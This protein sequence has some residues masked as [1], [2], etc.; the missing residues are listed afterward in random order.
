MRMIFGAIGGM[1]IGRGNGSTR[2]KPTP[3]PLC[4]PQNPT[5]PDPGSNP[6]PQRWRYKMVNSRFTVWELRGRGEKNRSRIISSLYVTV[7]AVQ[8]FRAI[9]CYANSWNCMDLVQTFTIDGCQHLII[10][11]SA[12]SR[13]LCAVVIVNDFLRELSQ[14]DQ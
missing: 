1:K 3:A 9:S 13:V 14:K 12:R 6:G 2:R 8:S 4:P 7:R 10:S 5:W 11:Q